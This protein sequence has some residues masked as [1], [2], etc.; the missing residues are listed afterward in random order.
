MSERKPRTILLFESLAS[1]DQLQ[2][3]FEH[4]IVATY[5]P[6][7]VICEKGA[8]SAD[9][10]V[11]MEGRVEFFLS[12]GKQ[13]DPTDLLDEQGAGE[14]FGELGLFDDKPRSATAVAKY[15]TMCRV[16]SGASFFAWLDANPSVYR[17]L[18]RDAAT[19]I[20]DLSDERRES[21]YT[22]VT[23]YL[24]RVADRDG[25]TCVIRN[26][27]TVG[28]VANRLILS[29]KYTGQIISD[30]VDGGHIKVEGHSWRW[31]YPLPARY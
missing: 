13:G 3:L 16:I 4:A 15:K 25:N 29:R 5:E 20:R 24:E 17:A 19:R 26:K 12:A 14:Y 10:F 11:I 22:R 31:Q 27:P 28:A 6:Q 9:L 2:S 30:L 23:R 21:A 8:S 1:P 7:R 18:L